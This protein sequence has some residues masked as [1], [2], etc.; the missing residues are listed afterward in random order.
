MTEIKKEFS[1][2]IMKNFKKGFAGSV[3]VSLAFVIMSFFHGLTPEQHQAGI[4]V[5]TGL[6][7]S[8][9]NMLKKK[10]PRLLSFF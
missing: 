1:F 9:R 8:S 4:V 3:I 2:S 5:S 10:F 6:L 7:E